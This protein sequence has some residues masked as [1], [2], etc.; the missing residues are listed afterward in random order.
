MNPGLLISRNYARVIQLTL[1]IRYEKNE[2]QNFMQDLESVDSAE[3]LRNR[4][5]SQARSIFFSLREC[6]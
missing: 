1:E 2:G 6:P 5:S 4:L 3:V